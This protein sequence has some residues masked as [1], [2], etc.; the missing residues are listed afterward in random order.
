MIDID[1]PTR[2]AL[3]VKGNV[4]PRTIDKVLRGERVRGMAGHRAR[5]ALREAGIPVPTVPAA[6][7]A[8]GR[9]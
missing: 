6:Q 3:A 2:R 4:D 8:E 9:R 7:D 1:W 5:A